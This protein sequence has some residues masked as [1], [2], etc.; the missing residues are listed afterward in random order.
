MIDV[1]IEPATSARW[2][3]LQKVLGARGQAAACQCQRAVLPMREW[4]FMP[5]DERRSLLRREITR[6]PI[7]P[8]LLA[9]VDGEP[10]GW[11]RLGP[12]SD[13][14][15]LRNSPVP[16]SGRDEDKDDVRVWALVCFVVRAG[17]RKRGVSYALAAAAVDF[18]RRHG[19]A[20]LEGYP[21]ATDGGDIPWGELHVGAD[22]AFRSAGFEEVSHPSKRRYVMRI[23]FPDRKPKKAAKKR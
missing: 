23:D 22:G 1:T 16:W 20:A 14:P 5:R 4:W 13:F 21:M 11:C 9:Y 8:G 15:P 3:D 17:H 6:A 7:A 18:A 10:V 2:S 19:A 12:R